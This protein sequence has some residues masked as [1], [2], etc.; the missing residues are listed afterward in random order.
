MLQPPWKGAGLTLASHYHSLCTPPR[1]KTPSDIT[2]SF[3]GLCFAV[4]LP[5]P[6]LLLGR[7]AGLEQRAIPHPCA[8]QGGWGGKNWL[9][10]PL[11]SLLPSPPDLSSWHLAHFPT[12][13]QNRTKFRSSK[14]I[15]WVRAHA[16]QAGAPDPRLTLLGPQ[17][18]PLPGSVPPPPPDLRALGKQKAW[19][20]FCFDTLTTL[21]TILKSPDGHAAPAW[22][23]HAGH[24]EELGLRCPREAVQGEEIMGCTARFRVDS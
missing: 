6:P 16:N 4:L 22:S 12:D 15:A 10:F 1:K 5:H 20:S 13:F 21:L 7:A 17:G 24:M 2:E 14:S 18:G 8:P 3:P 11:S 23:G 9:A 19:P